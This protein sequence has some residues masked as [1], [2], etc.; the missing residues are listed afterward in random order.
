[1]TVASALTGGQ[2]TGTFSVFRR[3]KQK[4]HLCDVITYTHTAYEVVCVLLTDT[5][6]VT[7]HSS[8]ESDMFD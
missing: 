4:H 8:A 3:V 6:A 1:M 7:C 2:A 5:V